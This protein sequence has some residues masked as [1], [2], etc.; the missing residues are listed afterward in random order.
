[1]GGDALRHVVQRRVHLERRQPQRRQHLGLLEKHKDYALRAKDYKAKEEA[2]RKL[3]EA[4][5]LKNPDE[6][7]FKMINA[8]SLRDGKIC[9]REKDNRTAQQKRNADLVDRTFVAARDT[10]DRKQLEKLE[11][12]L[13]AHGSGNG[14]RIEFDED[15]RP[16][17]ESRKRTRSV[18]FETD[19]TVAASRIVVASAP[20]KK[21][22]V[23][24]LKR[25]IDAE[26][27]AQAEHEELQRKK[28]EATRITR[29]LDELETRHKLQ[30]KG[31]HWKVGETPAGLPIYK[32]KTKRLR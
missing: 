5:R 1:M 17:P 12:T 25:L 30:K 7:N 20:S 24:R 8:E 32:W 15:G 16:K 6:F 4:A 26:A 22:N 2:I 13:S 10:R 11:A 3:E 28:H 19:S 31:E 23:R 14:R 29:A 27:E 9:F 18:A 21:E